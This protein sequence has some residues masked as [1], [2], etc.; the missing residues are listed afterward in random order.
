MSAKKN[1]RKRTAL[2]YLVILVNVHGFILLGTIQSGTA[3]ENR[4][5]NRIARTIFAP[6]Q[7]KFGALAKRKKKKQGKAPFCLFLYSCL[8]FLVYNKWGMLSQTLKDCRSLKFFLQGHNISRKR[9]QR[10]VRR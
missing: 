2:K 4:C 7:F 10:K 6:L 3:K 9:K 8:S 5:A 1:N